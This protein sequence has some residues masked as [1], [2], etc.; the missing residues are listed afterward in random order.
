MSCNLLL[1]TR[2]LSRRPYLLVAARY[3]FLA[4]S[5]LL[6]LRCMPNMNSAA[7]RRWFAAVRHTLD[8]ELKERLISVDEDAINEHDDAE[9]RTDIPASSSTTTVILVAH[10]YGSQ[11]LVK[12]RDRAW[13]KSWFITEQ[14]RRLHPTSY[15]DGLR[16]VA[17]FFVFIHHSSIALFPEIRNSFGV[18]GSHNYLI[19]LPFLRIVY[20]GSAM[21][22]V[23][24]VI[25]GA[26]LTLKPL[27][28][29]RDGEHL[30]LLENL[31]SSVFR[32]G[33]RL[34]IP[35][36]VSTFVTAFAS[37]S[38]L[39]LRKG[40]TRNYP[41]SENGSWIEQFT[42]W[43]SDMLH[44]VKP[45]ATGTPWEQNLWTIPIEFRGSLL[46]FLCALGVAKLRSRRMRTLSLILLNLYWFYLGWWSYFLFLSGMIVSEFSLYRR[47]DPLHS[48]S[49]RI[50]HW[51]MIVFAVYLLSMPEKG[52]HLDSASFGFSW[53]H[54]NF[55][56]SSWRDN[57]EPGRFWPCFGAV[58]FVAVQT[59]AGP[60]SY[61][62]RAFTSPF[63][64]YLGEISFSFYL[65]HGLVIYT[66]GARVMTFM[67]DTVGTH[68]YW[69]WLC[70]LVTE[71]AMLPTLF[72]I[73]NLSTQHVDKAA[74]KFGRWLMEL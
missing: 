63:I 34:F 38:G 11:F 46:V 30:K 8:E 67:M 17:S 66:V 53:F 40:I 52:E 26:V 28:L 35:C 64:Q 48:K 55:S 21:V 14:E 9:K 68:G 65:W 58:L 69:W 7:W 36:F 22:D 73:S 44:Y 70:F 6:T 74:V 49:M 18:E 29:V 47:E 71:A 10:H 43:F 19:Q 25:S 56:P 54:N 59:H 60:A 62:Q 16:G 13:L 37:I 39:M 32:R 15:L 42:T 27:R 23:F 61:I 51:A 41:L 45:D 20:S 2:V 1:S 12:I 24:F 5:V 33:P 50:F 57:L 4:T 31:S 3:P 72:M